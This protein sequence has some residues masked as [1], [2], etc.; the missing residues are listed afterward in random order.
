M[1]HLVDRVLAFPPG[2]A[3][4]VIFLV[5]AA[6][7]SV[8]AGFLFPGE[9]AILLGGVLANQGR[10]PL[11]SV[12][13]VGTLG[14]AIGDS[15]GYE[16][17][18][19]YGMSLLDKV[20]KRLLKPEHIARTQQLLRTKGGRAVFIGRF[21]AALRVLVPGMAGMSR[22]DYRRFVVFNV[23]GAIAWVTETALV[24]YV[25]GKSYKAAE[26][27]LSLISLAILALVL[28][29]FGYRYVRHSSS[30]QTWV[31]RHFGWAYRLEP[32]LI[33]TAAIAVGGV[34]LLAGV[35]QDVTENDGVTTAD[36]RILHDVI[37]HRT[38]ALTHLAKA[39]T[40]LGTGPIVYL[41]VAISGVIA[42]RTRHHWWPLILA[43]G[44]LLSG[45][46]IRL[47]IN[48]SVARPRPPH[49]LWLM[50]AGGYAY[51]SGH[52]TT[53]A[54]GYVVAAALLVQR[55]PQRRIAIF[56]VAGLCAVAVGMSRVYLGVHWPTDVLGGWLLAVSWLALC[57]LAYR[58]V[59]IVWRRV[60][61]SHRR[62]E[63]S[64]SYG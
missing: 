16:V 56:S 10:L 25:V 50:H 20:P 48:R 12:I 47:S 29:F 46:L 45:Q 42:V 55:W 28:L 4:V 63:I 61:R 2:W 43:A 18:R 8:F 38:S 33:F 60:N 6:E 41:V 39:V 15:I 53:A 14:A 24:G 40:T 36:P 32:R 23:L 1:S 44:V 31:R 5:P 64:T 19:H 7:A 49:D 11:W 27:R 58:V 9:I 34:V 57:T 52:T 35:T 21:T 26:H 51:P 22:L 30:V 37:A 62:D 17:G 13:V 3:L 59:R 54:L